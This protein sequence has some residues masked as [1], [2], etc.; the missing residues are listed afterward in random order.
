MSFEDTIA[1]LLRVM[2]AALAYAGPQ[3]TD[4]V[5]DK[6]QMA[7]GFVDGSYFKKILA[8]DEVSE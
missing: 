6:M 4:D 2:A 1:D 3:L 5:E 7:G 8:E